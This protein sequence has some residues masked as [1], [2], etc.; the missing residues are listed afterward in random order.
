M[1]TALVLL[2]GPLVATAQSDT[3]TI[4]KAHSEI[5]FSVAHMAISE[6][7]GKFKDFDVVF[8]SSK[9][10]FSDAS[11]KAV[12]NVSSINTENERRDN[13]LK[14]GDFFDAAK[15]PTISFTSTKFEKVGE[16]QYKITGDL[17]IRDVTRPATFDAEHRGTIES[18]NELRAGW[19]AKT[20]V[21]RF[22]YNVQWNKVLETGN[23]VA[24][25]MVDIILS[26]EFRKKV[27]S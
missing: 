4:D 6:V 13:H 5:S 27:S 14:S 9:D 22:D 8:T 2:F 26:L 1:Q 3:W 24:G 16:N 11:V 7:T 19:K 10:D 25:N 12:I 15:Y 17:T 21:N 18:I 23:L 20:T